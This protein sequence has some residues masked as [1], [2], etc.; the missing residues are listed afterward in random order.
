[1]R[2]HQRTQDLL[3]FLFTE[4]CARNHTH[5]LKPFPDTSKRCPGSIESVQNRNM[6]YRAHPAVS[7]ARKPVLPLSDAAVESIHRVSNAGRQQHSKRDV[8]VDSAMLRLREMNER[9]HMPAFP[10]TSSRFSA[11]LLPMNTTDWRLH[12]MGGRQQSRAS[13]LVSTG[14][15]CLADTNGTPQFQEGGTSNGSCLPQSILFVRSNQQHR[16]LASESTLQLQ[17]GI[18]WSWT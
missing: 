6:L 1:M 7:L 5:R 4:A 2:S 13:C 3:V 12:T 9:M 8:A 10:S 17:H 11:C 14:F 18:A 15:A 16:Q